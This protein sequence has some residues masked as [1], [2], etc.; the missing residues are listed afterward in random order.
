M[1]VARTQEKSG[2]DTAWHPESLRQWTHSFGWPADIRFAVVCR[3]MFNATHGRA[4]LF[5]S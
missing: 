3:K 5:D 2:S 4:C 1:F